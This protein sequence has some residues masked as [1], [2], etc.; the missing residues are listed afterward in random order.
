[1]VYFG[2]SDVL[3]SDC[4]YD[5]SSGCEKKE[6]ERSSDCKGGKVCVPD[7]GCKGG[8]ICDPGEGKDLGLVL[9]QRHDAVARILAN[10]SAAFFESCAAIG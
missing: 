3:P 1:M 6:C 9:L 8:C 5:S 2:N 4:C 10:G 7:P